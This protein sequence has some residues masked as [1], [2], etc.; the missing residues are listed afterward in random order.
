MKTSVFFAVV[1]LA[2]SLAITASRGWSTEKEYG[3]DYYSG[4]AMNG[5]LS[6]QIHTIPFSTT[7]CQPTAYRFPVYP[8]VL[9]VVERLFGGESGAWL[10]QSVLLAMI[11]FV[12]C[13]LAAR[14]GGYPAIP[15]I[16][17]ALDLLMY[18][19]ASWL[20]TELLYTFLTLVLLVTLYRKKY[21][22]SGLLTGVILLTRGTFLLTIPL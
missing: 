2:V 8:I 15:G 12:T 22:A 5:M 10:F 1:V 4:L 9:G 17:L 14:Q 20:E 11:T 18:V 19:Y 21:V 7:N 6:C 13:Q 3:F 16:A